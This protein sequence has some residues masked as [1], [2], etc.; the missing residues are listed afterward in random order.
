MII[1]LK[2]ESIPVGCL[3]NAC[4][5]HTYFNSHQMS[6]ALGGPEVTNYE[7]VSSDDCQMSPAKGSLRS[8]V[9]EGP[10]QGSPLGPMSGE[11]RGWD[12]SEWLKFS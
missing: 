5:D 7:Q 2:Q 9:Q 12:Q 10:G 6:D 11:D 8:Y 3:P 1:D 4:A